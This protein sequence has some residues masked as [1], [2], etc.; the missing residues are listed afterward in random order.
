MEL[1]KLVGEVALNGT[2]NVKNEL[3]DI[4][5]KGEQSENRLISAFKK[6]GSAVATYFAVNKITN[7]GMEIARVSAEVGAESSAFAQIMGD[8][9][10]QAK[11]KMQQVAD[12]TGVM[13]TR[14][15][16]YMTS[17]TAKF[18]GLGYGINDATTFA[19]QGLL[20]ASD[21]SAFWDMSLDE[22][23]SHLNSFINGSYEGGEAI[24]LFANDTQMA[25]Y[26]IKTGL[27]E[28]KKEW[29]NLDEAIKQATRLEYAQAMM[30]ASGAV[31]QAR[32][33]AGQ[34][35]NQSADLTEKWR[36]FKAEIGEPI[37]QNIVVPAM[38]K[39]SEIVDKLSQG[40]KDLKVWVED[41]RKK[42][43]ETKQ[44]CEEHQTLLTIITIAIGGVT[45]ALIAYNA[46]AIAK[47]IADGAMTVAI[48]AYCTA[49]TVA[50]TVTTAFG[51]VI[52][53]LTSPI[54]LIILGITALIA[55]IVLLWNKCDWF[56]EG[57]INIVETIKNILS[58]AVQFIGQLFNLLIDIILI[59][60]NFIWQNFGDTI[61]KWI[62]VAKE[63]LKN[64]FEFIKG[65]FTSIWNTITNVFNSIKTTITNIITGIKNKVVEIFTNIKDSIS[66]KINA[67]KT[68][69]TN[70]FNK[71]KSAI[72]EP[73]ENAK[74]KVGEVVDNIKS[75][76][77]F[78][79]SL[80][81]I[82][83][84]HFAVT[85][86]GWELGD[87]L[88]GKVPKLGIEWYAKAMDKGMILDEP[89]IFG[90]N[91]N[92]VPMGAGEAGSETVVGTNSLMNMINKAVKGNTQQVDNSGI[93]KKLDKIMEL[94]LKM[95]IELDD[96][97]V[98]NF[99]VKTVEKEVFN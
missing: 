78:N 31:G 24:G 32:K 58:V 67:V 41:F 3:D 56:R 68:T 75:M 4:S 2:D 45:T 95:K 14:L 37:L 44:W 36:Q 28:S 86:K 11:E 9:S 97:V 99:V 71:V 59:P 47:A 60:W 38:Q 52:A 74:K 1:F 20:L 73:I 53:F 39:L 46:A 98:G 69:V 19:T 83:L 88:K 29:A 82:K 5:D 16:P 48:W 49:T 18:K 55:T 43:E 63:W 54:T 12:A 87:L 94:M 57:I 93:E 65:I 25:Q 7:F 22:S 33:E 13:S 17:M 66:E 96:E 15:T 70:V 26:A 62:N 34:Y 76:F 72:T 89:T 50:T 8:Y 42:I 79:V 51:A 6:I 61:M 81:K 21:A 92:G 27:I 85:P 90:I 84:P 10:Q 91:S 80:P 35:A 64:V 40:Y 77:K 23:V 30:E